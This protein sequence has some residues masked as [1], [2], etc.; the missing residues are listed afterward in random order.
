MRSIVISAMIMA[1]GCGGSGS[2]HD[3]DH[4]ACVSDTG[5]NYDIDVAVDTA[6]SLPKDEYVA[7]LEKDSTKGQF[8][9]QLLLSDP[10]P[11]YTD[12]YTW[13]VI[14][15]DVEGNPVVD[16]DLVAEPTMP[17]H[18]HGTFP[19]FTNAV[20]LDQ[21]GEYQLVDMDLFMPGVWQV[22]IRITVGDG[23]VDQVLYW[24]ELEG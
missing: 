21:P 15:Q 11:R 19:K 13:T 6:S 1:V 5:F 24:F 16:A 22:D 23:S 10:I 9:M 20:A 3:H 14:L 17:E 2:S 8:K 4:G 18:K 7:G 12:V